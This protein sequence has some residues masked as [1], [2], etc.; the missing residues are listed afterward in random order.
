M[1]LMMGAMNTL[2]RGRSQF[3]KQLPAAAPGGPL[4]YAMKVGNGQ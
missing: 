2:V 3:A 4:Q 1:Y